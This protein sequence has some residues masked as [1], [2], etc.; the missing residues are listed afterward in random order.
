M[1]YVCVCVFFVS[2]ISYFYY[3]LFMTKDGSIHLCPERHPHPPSLFP[4]HCPQ[5]HHPNPFPPPHYLTSCHNSATPHIYLRCYPCN[6]EIPPLPSP[7]FSSPFSLLSSLPSPLLPPSLPSLFPL[8][9][10]SPLFSSPFSPLSLLSSPSFP[11]LSLFPLLPPQ[12]LIK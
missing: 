11:P 8:L 9:P 10:P 3:H 12:L 5:L 4:L 7:L 2:L 1:F 6:Q